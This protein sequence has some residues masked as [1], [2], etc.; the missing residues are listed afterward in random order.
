MWTAE[1]LEQRILWGL[2]G[3]MAGRPVPF[4]GEASGALL[5]AVGRCRLSGKPDEIEVC[6]RHALE[7]GCSLWFDGLVDEGFVPT[8]DGQ[9][10]IWHSPRVP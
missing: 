5:Q 8:E 4:Y 2:D 3:T 10:L 7:P 6:L 9:W 1:S